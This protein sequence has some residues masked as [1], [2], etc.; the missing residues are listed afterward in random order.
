MPEIA[1]RLPVNVTG[2]FYVDATC[3]D[4]DLCRNTAPRFFTRD[5]ELGQSY[6]HRQP[7]T[8]EE[9]ELALEAMDECPSNSIGNDG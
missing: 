1:E 4:C 9:H 6:V 5:D 7:T 8:D 3:I 2:T